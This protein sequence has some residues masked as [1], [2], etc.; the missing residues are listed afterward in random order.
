MSAPWC[1]EHVISLIRRRGARHGGLE[2]SVSLAD[3]ALPAFL[4]GEVLP[5]RVLQRD[6]VDE[7]LQSPPG[8]DVADHQDAAPVLGLELL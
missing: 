7:V 2:G 1:G 5:G 3:S 6:A 4:P 8:G